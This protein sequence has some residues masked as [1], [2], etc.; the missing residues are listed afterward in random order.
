MRQLHKLPCCKLRARD[1]P[2]EGGGRTIIHFVGRR[3]VWCDVTRVYRIY[4]RRASEMIQKDFAASFLRRCV[5]ARFQDEV[6]SRRRFGSIDATSRSRWRLYI[7]LNVGYRD[8][9]F[10]FEV[11]NRGRSGREA[12]M[13]NDRAI[14]QNLLTIYRELILESFDFA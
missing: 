14:Y 13:C 9:L 11:Y 1:P 4:N 7:Y 6:V 5:C 2:A 3:A 8:L 10:I 12:C